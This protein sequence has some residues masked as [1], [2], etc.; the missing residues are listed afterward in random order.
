MGTVEHTG[1]PVQIQ[2]VAWFRGILGQSGSTALRRQRLLARTPG[3]GPR[4][5]MWRNSLL[6]QERCTTADQLR[7]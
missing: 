5:H 6:Q 4:N 3:N 2:L 7:C 1:V